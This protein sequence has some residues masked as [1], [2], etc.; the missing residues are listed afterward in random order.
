V[1]FGRFRPAVEG[2]DLHQDV[3][4]R[5]LGVLDKDIEI[6]VTVENAGI[7][8]FILELVARALTVGI[9][10]I[11]IGVG[12]LGILVEILH[13]GVGGGAV[14]VEVVFLDVLAVVPFTVGESE[15][16]FLEDRVFAVPQ[17]EGEA[18]A[19]LPV[20]YAGEAVLPPAVGPR[21]GVIVSEVV[22]G[23]AALAV[24]LAHGPPLSL[25]E[26]RPPL[27]P[28]NAL[29][30]SFIQPFLLLG[31]LQ[32]LHV[33]LLMVMVKIPETTRRVHEGPL[34]C[35]FFIAFPYP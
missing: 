21:A 34:G 7:E 5:F 12:G 33:C 30:A 31:V 28:G 16:A 8:Q 11:R 22:P 32:R 29:F 3:F 10:Q 18:E 13:V 6:A 25:A 27:F 35:G 15:E 24:V 2:G 1:Q 17:G 4:R 26:I 20:G 19:L 9:H 14:E 23:I